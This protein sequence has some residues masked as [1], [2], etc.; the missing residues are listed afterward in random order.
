[1][2]KQCDRHKSHFVDSGTLKGHDPGEEKWEGGGQ[3]TLTIAQRDYEEESLAAEAEGT[4]GTDRTEMGLWQS[5][6]AILRQKITATQTFLASIMAIISFIAIWFYGNRITAF[7]V[8]VFQR[9]ST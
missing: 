9:F 2:N 1:M 4:D 8:S 7:L 5:F 3:R 6:L